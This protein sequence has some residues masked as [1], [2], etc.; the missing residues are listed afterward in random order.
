MQNWLL[1]IFST[2]SLLFT[3]AY[4]SIFNYLSIHL[5]NSP[6]RARIHLFSKPSTLRSV[7]INFSSFLLSKSYLLVQTLIHVHT[8][9]NIQWRGRRQC[10]YVLRQ[11]DKWFDSG[12]FLFAHSRAYVIQFLSNNTILPHPVALCISDLVSRCS[13]F[14]Y[15]FSV[16]ILLLHYYK[17][18]RQMK[19]YSYMD[20]KRETESVLAV[21]GFFFPKWFIHTEVR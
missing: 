1:L 17:Q 20:G 11:L 6:I 21:S 18:E 5:I 15:S 7:S 2:N 8:F 4:T 13:F 3:P 12:A 14:F 9:L 19:L 10:M 16:F